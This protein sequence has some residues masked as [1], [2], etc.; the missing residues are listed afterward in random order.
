MN[1]TRFS[2]AA[3]LLAFG[4]ASPPAHAEMMEKDKGMMQDK[5]MMD[6]QMTGTLT[7]AKDHHAN[8]T[9][10]LTKDMGGHIVLRLEN[11]K[12]DKVPDGRVYLAK[13]GDYATGADLGKLTTFSGTVEFP[14]PPGVNPADYDSVVIWCKKFSVEIGRA[15]FDTGVMKKDNMMMDRQKGMMK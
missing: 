13:D 2:V 9:V 4:L 8:G 14:I 12:V 11:L 15:M 1:T 7:G 3:L 5:G 6:G 10:A